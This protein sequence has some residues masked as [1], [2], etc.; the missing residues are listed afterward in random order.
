MTRT[1][2]RKPGAR[3]VGTFVQKSPTTPAN[4]TMYQVPCIEQCEDEVLEGD[5]HPFKVQRWTQSGG[6]ANGIWV[7][8][9]DPSRTMTY[10]NYPLSRYR[11]DPTDISVHPALP[12]RPAYSELVTAI[13]SR[14]NPSRP[15]VDL[16]VFVAELRDFPK[17]FRLAGEGLFGLRKAASANLSYQFGWKPLIGDLVKLL[18]FS[19]HFRKRAADLKRM[20]ESGLTRKTELYRGSL[21][22]VNRDVTAESLDGIFKADEITLTHGRT[23]GYATWLYDAKPPQ[24]DA[25]FHAQA[26]RAV[27]GLTF[28]PASA[29]E[30]IPFSWLIDWCGNMGDYLVASR[31]IVGASPHS[32]RICDHFTTERTAYITST[33]KG[34]HCSNW[35]LS[36]ETKQRRIGNPSLPTASLPFLNA[37]QLSILGSIGLLTGKS[38]GR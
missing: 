3:V 30:L 16:P 31:N 35:K 11:D 20:A 18:K 22:S 6:L 36:Y 8:S 24:T 4:R 29:W 10:N 26:V 19:E 33:P 9:S 38:R 32:I 15:V 14:T 28:D 34:V 1:R 13:V 12:D 25:Q 17:L 21:R 5:N 27:L 37:R 7:N 23:W 2:T